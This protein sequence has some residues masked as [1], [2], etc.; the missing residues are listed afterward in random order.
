M[1][2]AARRQFEQQ[3]ILSAAGLNQARRLSA[4]GPSV[5]AQVVARYQVAAALLAM[6]FAPLV[7]DEQGIDSGAVGRV[8]VDSVLTGSATV[9]LVEKTQTS[10]AFDSLILSLIL[11]A[12]RTAASVD[13]ATR[14]AVTGYVRSLQPPSC[15]RCAILA[16]RVYRYSTGFRRHPRCDCLMTPTNQAIGRSL[17]TDARAAFDDGLIRG[18]SRA[19]TEAIRAG[20]DI[21]QVVNVRK[22]AAGLTEGSSV[23]ARNGR[24]TP[25]GIYRMAADDAEA[26]ALFRRFGYV[27]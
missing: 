22:R 26:L 19:D 16:G 27:L 2:T 11:D 12:G 1:L 20:A 3:A 6:E 23:L 5:V 15:S 9:G 24:P 14:P 8:A 18:L 17:V 7:L 10:A 13:S 25:A 21:G 4:R